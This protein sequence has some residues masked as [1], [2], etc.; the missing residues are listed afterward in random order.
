M[1]HKPIE[2]SGWWINVRFSD[3]PCNLEPKETIYSTKGLARTKL[4]ARLKKLRKQ[5]YGPFQKISNLRYRTPG[6][7][8]IRYEILPVRLKLIGF[9]ATGRKKS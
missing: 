5:G 3:D 6:V 2:I 7:C 4:L 9:Q 1:K 8:E